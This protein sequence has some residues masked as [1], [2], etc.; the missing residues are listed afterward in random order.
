MTFWCPPRPWLQAQSSGFFIVMKNVI[1]MYLLQVCK[2]GTMVVF[3]R[4]V[5]VAKVVSEILG[6]RGRRACDAYSGLL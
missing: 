1:V 4:K 5:R 2:T 3:H 6:D